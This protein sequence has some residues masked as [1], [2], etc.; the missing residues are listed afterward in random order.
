ML[1]KKIIRRPYDIS[2]A[3]R[4]LPPLLQ[5]VYAAR[6]ISEPRQLERGAKA[7]LDFS[8]LCHMNAAVSV[9]LE[10][11]EKRQHI[12]IVGD[13]DA[14]G[15]T[16]TS[17]AVRALKNFAAA[18]VSYLVPN[19]FDFGYGLTPEIVELAYQQK[20]D[21]LITVDNG[22]ANIAGVRLANQLGMRVIITD[23]HLPGEQ[24][25]PATAIVNPN[26]P[27]CHFASKSLAG[28][29]V[30]FYVMVALRAALRE[31]HW[32]EQQQIPEANMADLL[33]L[34]ALGTVADLVPLDKNN[35]ILVYQGLQ[36]IRCGKC[37]PAI[38]ALLH[39]AKR[40][41]ATVA[42]TDL[43][44]AVG[45]R[46]NAAGRLQ[47]MSLGI[48]CLLSDDALTAEKNAEQ[49]H[50][51]NDER[52][53]I[54]ADMQQQA[55]TML[56]TIHLSDDLPYGLCLFDKN[57]HQGLIGILASKIKNKT[58]RPVIIFAEDGN[59]KL[60]GSARSISGIH[61]RDVLAN[62]HA[63]HPDLITKFGGHAMA[64]GLSI[65]DTDFNVF[66]KAFIDELQQFV[67]DD[68]LQAQLITDGELTTDVLNLDTVALLQQAGP[69]GQGFPEPVFDGIFDIIDQRLLAE[70]HLKLTLKKE[71]SHYEAIAFFIDNT[72]WPNP[73][74]QQVHIVYRPDCNLYGGISK[75]QLVV[76][77]LEP[78]Y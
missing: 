21:I 1:Q 7:L 75:L 47:D 30:I 4:H 15:A 72:L 56:N 27:T 11:I 41:P 59:G 33:D 14:D 18:K 5:R 58:H 71:A 23:H 35:R 24:L 38:T 36:R 6:G 78:V 64:A 73:R 40:D 44:F 49:L 46:L 61:I 74:C 77:Y 8:G 19:R 65:A 25:P 29:G 10:A 39:L 63:K 60:K 17:L 51:L 45:P 50:Q 42:A 28:V 22:I 13:Y 67:T 66:Q 12:M 68:L 52:R 20:P 54:E 9:L 3:M 76:E 55:M 53:Q 43:A 48:E 26:Q 69:W 62:I 57:W 70:K 2:S 37:C 32:F 34:V 31:K 16:G